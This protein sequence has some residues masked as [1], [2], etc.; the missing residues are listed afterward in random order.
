M[1]TLGNRWLVFP[2]YTIS[3]MF[4]VDLSHTDTAI[5]YDVDDMGNT[6]HETRYGWVNAD[7]EK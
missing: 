3:S 6:T 4:D 2:A 1:R 5:G 7:L